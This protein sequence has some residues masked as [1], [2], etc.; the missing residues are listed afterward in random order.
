MGR[1]KHYREVTLKSGRT[2]YAFDP[3]ATL[4]NKLG[5]KWEPYNT[6]EQAQARA[7]E[8][9][10]AFAD[11]KRIGSLPQSTERLTVAGLF[12]AYKRTSRW[13]KITA[14]PNSLRAYNTSIKIALAA[15]ISSAKTLSDT[16]VDE[17]TPMAAEELYSSLCDAHSASSANSVIKVLSVVWSNGERLQLVKS[18]PFSKLGLLHVASREVVWT[19][20]Q[21]QLAVRAADKHGLSSIGTIILMA[22]DLCQRPGDCRQMQWANYNDG[23]FRFTQEKTGVTVEVPASKTLAARLGAIASNRNPADTIAMYEGTGKPYS[24]RLYR[25]KAQLVREHAGLPSDLKVADLRRTGATLLGNSSCSEDEIRAV[26]GHQSRQILNTY[27]KT[28]REMA[29]A[30]QAKRFETGCVAV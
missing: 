30:A 6:A 16:W 7:I 24:D 17:V 29:A 15:N 8:A 22:F 13:K 26:T 4:R 20:H 25:K 3:S 12:A 2:V 19:E 1:V 5:Y 21:V 23:L 18:N 11:F 10:N 9:A 28:N 27:V 14:K